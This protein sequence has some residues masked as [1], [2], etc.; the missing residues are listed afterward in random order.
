MCG[1][2]ME[3]SLYLIYTVCM[4]AIMT[5]RKNEDEDELN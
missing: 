4:N 5:I 2:V 3:V 1:S